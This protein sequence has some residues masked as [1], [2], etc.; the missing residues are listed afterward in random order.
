MAPQRKVFNET[1]DF[2][3]EELTLAMKWER[4]SILL[5]VHKS[6]PSQRKAE[7]ALKNKLEKIG[8][9]VID[10][11]LT[12]ESSDAADLI[13]ASKADVEK[14]VFFI[15]NI[16]QGGGEDGRNAYR[17]L[18]LH[19]E[20]FVENKI[21]VVFWLT[22]NEELK[23]PLYAPD[24]W[25]F[26]HRVFEFSSTHQS[27]KM[28]P[29]VGLLLWGMQN[30]GGSTH[31]AHEKIDSRKQL[32]S[33]LPDS[34]ESLSTRI[35]VLHDL[36]FLY[37]TLGDVA[38]ASDVLTSAVDL[39]KRDEFINIRTQLLNEQAIVLYEKE[40]YQEAYNIYTD[41]IDKNPKSSLLRINFAVVLS[42]L[43]KNYLAVSQARKALKLDPLNFEI[44]YVFGYLNYSLGKLD[45][46]VDL[47]KKSIQLAPITSELYEILGI[48][49]S[50][51]GLLDDARDQLMKASNLQGDRV[52]YSKICEEALFGNLDD[53]ATRL[54]NAIVSGEIYR[55]NT[56]RDPSLNAVFGHSRLQEVV[57]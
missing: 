42:A 55:Q 36:G 29:P 2:L 15:S 12:S 48:C 1:I 18:N 41:L 38:Q 51:M 6:R 7:N 19:R 16:D 21:K 57:N 43:G 28:I 22:I 5:A 50:K 9:N 31:T 4:P 23:L 24:F 3:L 52:L 26:R 13:L 30:R 49:Y 10:I 53:A 37:W 45:E 44:L 32:L 27:R 33:E 46:A 40:N 54:K 11:K 20:T 47:L 56:L 14:N 34:P 25:A 17:G 8:K 35:E 39:A